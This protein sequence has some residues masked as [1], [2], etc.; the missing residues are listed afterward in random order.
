MNARLAGL[1]V[2]I[3]V[4]AGSVLMPNL[5]AQDKKAQKTEKAQTAS[6][7]QQN[8]QGTVQDIS[9]DKSMITVRNGTATRLV[10]Y[11]ASTKFLYGHSNDSKPGSVAQLKTSNYISCVA[12]LDAKKELLAS[13]CVYRE[14]K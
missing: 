1:A 12:A 9:K 8:V 13:E 5:A 14:T 3:A 6:K 2:S 11:N 7:S 10:A 4:L